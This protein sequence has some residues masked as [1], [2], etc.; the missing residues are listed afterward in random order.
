MMIR[1]PLEGAQ[2][3]AYRSVCMRLGFLAQDFPHIQVAFKE[4]SKHMSNPTVGGWS[5]LKRVARFLR[6]KPRCVQYF[7]YQE[8]VYK[9]IIKTDCDFAGDVIARKSISSVVFLHGRHFLRPSSTNQTVIVLSTG[10]AESAAVVKGCSI[11]LGAVAM[12]QDLGSKLSLEI[13]T[14][15]SA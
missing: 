12:A 1:R 6:G 14:D 2:A 15:S 13:Q 3:K 9:V 8:E 10:E 5:K 11:G 7:S 4:A